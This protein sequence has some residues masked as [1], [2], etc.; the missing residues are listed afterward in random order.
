MFDNLVAQ[1]LGGDEAGDPVVK[2]TTH[3]DGLAGTGAAVKVVPHL[4]Q[5]QDPTLVTCCS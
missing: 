4:Q 5:T 1:E 2:A 3:A